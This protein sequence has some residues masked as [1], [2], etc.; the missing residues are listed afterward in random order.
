MFMLLRHGGVIRTV[1]VLGLHHYLHVPSKTLL[2]S[3]TLS[4][5]F[6]SC[7]AVGVHV[8]PFISFLHGPYVPANARYL[9]VVIWL[10]PAR[11]GAVLRGLA[12]YGISD[13]LQSS[14]VASQ[15]VPYLS[16]QHL[17]AP[18]DVLLMS[19]SLACLQDG[20]IRSGRGFVMFFFS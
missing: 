6:I 4:T 18:R 16:L 2:T 14:A 7:G 13:D 8:A 9:A 12:Y 20:L 19:A 17:R 15:P 5:R 11:L 3:F 10:D 1:F